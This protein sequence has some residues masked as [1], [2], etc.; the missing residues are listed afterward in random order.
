MFTCIYNIYMC[1]VIFICVNLRFLIESSL[2]IDILIVCFSM[3]WCY[4]IVSEKGGRFGTIKTFNPA[5]NVYTRPKSGTWCAVVV[6]CLCNLYAFLVF[7][8]IYILDRWFS[9]L[10]GFTLVILGPLIACCSVWA[11]APCWRPYID[12]Q[13]FPFINIYLDGELPHWHSHHIFLYLF[14]KLKVV[15]NFMNILNNY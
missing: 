11:K 2:S 8:Y 1:Y 6:V 3:L 10:N 9:R 15:F 7:F 4:T 14:I 5:A 12:L 13:W